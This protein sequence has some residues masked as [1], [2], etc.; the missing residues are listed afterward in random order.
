MRNAE[1][2]ASAQD[3]LIKNLHIDRI[4][5]W[6]TSSLEFDRHWSSPYGTKQRGTKEPLDKS[7]RGEW[8]AGLKLNIQEMKNMVSCPI[9]SWKIDGETMETMTD[10][11]FLS[12]K[13]TA[14]DNGAIKLKDA[15]SL[16]V[17][18]CP[19]WQHI[20]KHRHC[21]TDKGPSSQNHG[22]L[23]V[24]Y[25]CDSWTIKKA[26]CRRTGAFELWCWRR[27]LRVP[28]TARS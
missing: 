12:C 23:V 18:L 22:V 27:L 28:W 5:R 8:K 9:T 25:G 19:T 26:E 2:Q 24:M 3:L 14:D 20:E 7:E 6:F 17:K 15:S 4:P 16:E 21:F 10:F 11:I 13:V 1:F